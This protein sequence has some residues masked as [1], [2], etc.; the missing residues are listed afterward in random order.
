MAFHPSSKRVSVSM[1]EGK[2]SVG[3]ILLTDEAALM[4][5]SFLNA[6]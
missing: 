5:T 6:S 2:A 3:M 1:P 4:V